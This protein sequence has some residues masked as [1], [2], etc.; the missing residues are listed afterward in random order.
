V[1]S[2]N[3]ALLKRPP[4][5][6]TIVGVIVVALV[7][8]FA[9]MSPEGTKLSSVHAQQQQLQGQVGTLNATI[10]A[11]KV[12]ASQ[13]PAILPYLAFF[14]SAIPPLPQSGDLTTEL[15]NLS[16]KTGT[17]IS[18]LG[19]STTNATT[20]GYSVIPVQIQLTGT[21]AGVLNFIKGIYS[22]QR[23]VTIQTLSLQPPGG[24]ANLL[25]PTNAQGFSASIGATA[26]TTYVATAVAP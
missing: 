18:S 7:W 26:Y 14:Q 15:Y 21:E 25:K 2:L 17:F 20:G 13:V 23:L 11:L 22:L 10:G 19:D 4:I 9:W 6:G 16:L 8:W 3:L 24:G 1:K 12:E 5:Y